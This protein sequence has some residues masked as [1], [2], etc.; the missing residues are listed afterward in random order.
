[1]EY[2]PLYQAGFQDIPLTQLEATF[3]TPFEEKARR[4]LLLIRFQALL[5]KFNET[6]LK[7]EIWIDGSFATQKPDPNDIDI[8]FFVDAI[9][10]NKLSPDLQAILEELNNRAL[11][12]IRY[13]CDVF[14]LPNNN[15]DNRSYWRGWFGFSRDEQPKGIIRLFI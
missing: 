12:Q 14:I 3:L 2:S 5:D 1:M 6:G 4:E 7:A 8:I 9:E 15:P 10:A 11:S 13:Y